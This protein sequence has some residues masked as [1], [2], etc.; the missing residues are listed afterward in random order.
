MAQVE[1][2][3]ILML[4]CLTIPRF[5]GT[6]SWNVLLPSIFE[7]VLIHECACEWG[8]YL[9]AFLGWS[10]FTWAFHNQTTFRVRACYRSRALR[11]LIH[12]KWGWVSS[13][14]TI[15]TR[16]DVVLLNLSLTPQACHRQIC[17]HN[18]PPPKWIYALRATMPPEQRQKPDK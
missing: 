10:T 14:I 16:F 4:E 3:V 17:P 5:V 8:C 11:H 13:V 18:Y 7:R 2:H 9:D 15:T 12:S 1:I 6:S